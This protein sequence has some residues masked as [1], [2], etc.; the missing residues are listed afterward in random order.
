MNNLQSLLQKLANNTSNSNNLN[1]NPNNAQ[2]NS[3]INSTLPLVQQSNPKPL[4]SPS[5]T[6]SSQLNLNN[7]QELIDPNN[8]FNGVAPPPFIKIIENTNTHSHH[9]TLWFCELCNY[10]TEYPSNLR[11]HSKSDKHRLALAHKISSSA[12]AAA[13]SGNS[14]PN[15]EAA[16]RAAAASL[17]ALSS[18]N[19]NVAHSMSAN[20]NLTSPNNSLPSLINSNNQ[21]PMNN[22]CNTQ[23]IFKSCLETIQNNT[24]NINQTNNNNNANTSM[25][26]N[27][28]NH[29]NFKSQD[30]ENFNFN[31]KLKSVKCSL[32]F[33]GFTSKV[34]MYDHLVNFH[35]TSLDNIKF[36]MSSSLTVPLSVEIEQMEA[37]NLKINKIKFDVMNLESSQKESSL[38]GEVGG[39]IGKA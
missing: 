15:L 9:K 29:N 23:N 37:H 16:A 17:T 25:N 4:A 5:T 33:S 12:N 7:I 11:I 10:K 21:H 20:L 34:S 13:A 1:N 2:N 26:N 18:N 24:N 27:N 30:E 36:L 38:L 31:L 14:N 28:N 6:S 3:N 22:T 19:S 32:C 8:T 39:V 35:R